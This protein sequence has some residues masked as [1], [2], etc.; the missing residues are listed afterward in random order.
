MSSYILLCCNEVNILPFFFFFFLFSRR[1][2][3]LTLTVTTER[4]VCA[5]FCLVFFLSSISA[6]LM[7]DWICSFCHH[8]TQTSEQPVVRKL[9]Q[10]I[11][12]VCTVD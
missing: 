2:S 11:R 3:V 9:Q 8:W 5:V 10:P 7:S 12:A 4:F 1:Y 6:V